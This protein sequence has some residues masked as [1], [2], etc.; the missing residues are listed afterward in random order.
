VDSHSLPE[1]DYYVLYYYPIK[2][3]MSMGSLVVESDS[4]PHRLVD[5]ALGRR[6]WLAEVGEAEQ[7]GPRN[8]TV[9][10]LPQL[11]FHNSLC[12]YC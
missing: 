10:S 2:S 9:I 12:S 6:P 3:K 8:E 4:S 1:N 5:L 11:L 7:V